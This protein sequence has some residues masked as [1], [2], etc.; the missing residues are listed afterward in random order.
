MSTSGFARTLA[1]VDSSGSPASW[2]V[3]TAAQPV[4]SWVLPPDFAAECSVSV[5]LLADEGMG[6]RSSVVCLLVWR[7]VVS[8]AGALGQVWPDWGE[9]QR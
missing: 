4:R 6:G 9:L 7:V 1:S 5:R 8:V 3:L 2:L